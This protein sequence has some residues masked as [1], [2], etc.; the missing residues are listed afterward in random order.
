M[1]D[2]NL[3]R[4][5]QVPVS[6]VRFEPTYEGW[7]PYSEYLAELGLAD[8]LSLPMRDGNVSSSVAIHG[9]PSRF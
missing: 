4:D 9:R 1:R 3:A 7:K 6:F 5:Q 2:G 8:V